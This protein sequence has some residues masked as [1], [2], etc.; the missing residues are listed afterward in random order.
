VNWKFSGLFGDYYETFFES[1]KIAE[2]DSLRKWSLDQGIPLKV[3]LERD[4]QWCFVDYFHL[5]GSV[6][7]KKIIMPIDISDVQT[8][9]VRIKM[10]FGFMF[11]EIDYIALGTE[12]SLPLQVHRIP[13][14]SAVDQNGQDI[15]HLLTEDDDQY[16]IQPEIGDEGELTFAVP[17]LGHHMKRSVF[18]HS[19]GYYEILRSPEGAPDVP[20]LNSFKNPGRFVKFSK[21]EFLKISQPSNN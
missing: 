21:E 16:Y 12:E 13:L 20:L 15:L 11:W 8:E 9:E 18:L 4:G 7:P 17:S 1:R 19:K 5:V 14:E 2:E 3:Y 6:A 10:E